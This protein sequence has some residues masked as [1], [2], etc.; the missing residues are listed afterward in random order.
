M[1]EKS[2]L[3]LT[4]SFAGSFLT[5]SAGFCANP[6]ASNLASSFFLTPLFLFPATPPPNSSLRTTL[7]RRT[8]DL[9]LHRDSG[10]SPSRAA[11]A[12][13]DGSAP[14]LPRSPNECSVSILSGHLLVLFETSSFPHSFTEG[15]HTMPIST[16][17]KIH[18]EENHVP[19]LP[20]THP[21]SFTASGA[22]AVM[23]VSGAKSPRPS[24]CRPGRSITSS[25]CPLPIM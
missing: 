22:A 7:P 3:R 25:R 5:C 11:E 8:F 9:E 2:R 19:Y 15:S 12:A 17:I 24:S 4:H 20:L 23:H 21:S 14:H 13:H 6:C 16:R 1:R 18:L 10:P